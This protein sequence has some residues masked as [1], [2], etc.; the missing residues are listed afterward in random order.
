MWVLCHTFCCSTYFYYSAKVRAQFII[1]LEVAA[2]FVK[3]EIKS[4][5]MINMML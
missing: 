1:Q 4:K 5:G 2:I 3:N